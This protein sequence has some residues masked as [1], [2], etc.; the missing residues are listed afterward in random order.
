MRS[1]QDLLERFK[2]I[3]DTESSKKENITE[4]IKDSTGIILTSQ[5]LDV[6]AGKLFLKTKPIFR[7]E[8]ILKKEKVMKAFI[9]AF[10]ERYIRDIA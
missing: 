10:G 3:L 5:E 8:I 6:K 9:E 2:G 4:I 7:S 1:I